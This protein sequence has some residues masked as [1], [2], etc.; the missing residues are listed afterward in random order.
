MLQS[1]YVFLQIVDF[2]FLKVEIGRFRSVAE[3]NNIPSK[4]RI[5]DELFHFVFDFAMETYM[6]SE[7]ELF[8][9]CQTNPRI[10][11]LVFIK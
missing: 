5:A 4:W 7:P 3:I 10:Q 6:K 2:F 9:S 1:K 8:D 11:H